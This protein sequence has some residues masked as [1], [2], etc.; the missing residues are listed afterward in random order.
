MAML[1]GTQCRRHSFLALLTASCFL[2]LSFIM[3]SSGPSYGL[4]GALSVDTAEPPVPLARAWAASYPSSSSPLHLSSLPLLN[5]AQG[6][7][8]HPPHPRLIEA[9][10]SETS[11]N[12]MEA[13][14]YGPVFGDA[15]L[16]ES[17]A[18]DIS[19]RYLG[20]V[21]AKEVAI[22]SGCNLAAGVTFHAL[23]RPGEAVVLPTPWY[24]K[25]AERLVSGCEGRPADPFLSPPPPATR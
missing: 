5:L 6:V 3:A 13:H 11:R 25:C 8:G 17:L 7:P 15:S 18:R 19:E 4:N 2:P 14:G 10:A 16:R 12:S 22:T 24:F 1:P 20:S 23:A 9:M 21:S